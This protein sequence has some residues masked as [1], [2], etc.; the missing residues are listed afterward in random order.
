MMAGSS[1]GQIAQSVLNT[2]AIKSRPKM[3]IEDRK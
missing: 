2:F 1:T 3:K